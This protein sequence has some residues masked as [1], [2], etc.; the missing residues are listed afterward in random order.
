MRHQKRNPRQQS[1]NGGEVDEVTENYL[2]IICGVHESSAAE[3][4]GDGQSRYRHTT[5][6][7]PEKDL[8]GM[9]FDSKT[10]DRTGSNVKIRVGSAEGEEQDAGVD[11]SGEDRNIRK[12]DG[13]DERRSGSTGSSLVC[14]RQLLGIVGNNHAQ[15][16]D[17][18]AVEEQD[19]VE[20]KLN[21]ARDGLARVLGFS[22]G[23]TDKFSTEVGE[24]GVDQ[25]TPES[26]EFTSRATSDE[27]LER[28]GVIVVLEA[29]CRTRP[30]TDSKEER[31]EDDTNLFTSQYC[32]VSKSA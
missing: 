2:S 21:G 23:N 19:P 1:E 27:W 13:D 12:L 16:E 25:G 18:Q 28:T 15:E 24:D 10:V 14:E 11:D 32:F 6:I 30:S 3:K 22:N 4:S 17:R 9:A 26:V 31:E 29:S 20:G 8:R 7:S 5:L